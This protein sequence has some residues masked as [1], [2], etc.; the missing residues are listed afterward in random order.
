MCAGD[1]GSWDLLSGKLYLCVGGLALRLALH[2][3][4]N[5]EKVSRV[6]RVHSCKI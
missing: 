2:G 4:A 1:E 5:T 3:A 6:E